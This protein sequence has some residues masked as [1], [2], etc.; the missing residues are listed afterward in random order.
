MPT[1]A[2]IFLCYARPDENTVRELSQRL[3]AAGFNPWMDQEDIHPGEQWQASIDRAIH[4]SDFFLTCLSTHSV[5]R[6]GFLQR[7]IKTALDLWQEKLGSDIFL[8][9]ARLEP[10]EVP[11]AV[12]DCQWVNLYEERGW[13]RLLRAL[14]VGLERRAQ[15]T[16]ALGQETVPT[17]VAATVQRPLVVCHATHTIWTRR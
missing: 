3:T 11:E 16:E 8:I 5:S 15:L 2:Q 14:Q 6:R 1:P 9:A 7:E 10:C 17:S 12:A 13:P 4:R